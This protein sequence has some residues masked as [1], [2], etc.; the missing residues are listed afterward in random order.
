MKVAI[1]G[2][3]GGIGRFLTA[4]LAREQGFEPI[5]VL[6]EKKQFPRF[7]EIGVECRLGDLEGDF[8]EALDGT[9]AAVFTAGSGA[10]TGKDKTLL[11]DL[12]GAVRAIRHCE[13]SGPSRFIM[14][15]AR[16]AGDP[17]Q[18]EGGIKPYLVAKW[19]ADEALQRSRLDYTILRPGHL[20]DGPATG[21]LAVASSLD[22]RD[23]DV[24]R[25]DVADA[26]VAC[27][28]NPRTVGRVFEILNGDKP[29][30]RAFDV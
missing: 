3:N 13:K 5:A 14:V 2:A 21:K 16:R 25:E 11:V 1:I 18:A 20:T 26:I 28:G 7:E 19:A 6:R 27:L 24:T 4:R 29:L 17:D 15:S 12:W 9:I 10:K 30:T 22:D 23:G 8:T